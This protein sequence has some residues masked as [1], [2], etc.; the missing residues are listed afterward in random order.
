MK[1]NFNS[2]GYCLNNPLKYTDPS[3]YS[4]FQYMKDT[5]RGSE[6]FYYRGGEY[7]YGDDGWSYS[8]PSL[9]GGMAPA[10]NISYDGLHQEGY[11]YN[12]S[13]HNYHN[14]SGE[15]VTY[16]EVHNNYVIPNSDFS[17]SG[18]IAQDIYRA[19][20]QVLPSTN[21]TSS[22]DGSTGSSS[23]YIVSM[24]PVAFVMEANLSWEAA[25]ATSMTP[26]GMGLVLRGKNAGAVFFYS[27]GG[28]GGGW[29]GA[30]GAINTAYFFYSGD[31]NK[32]SQYSLGGKST[33]LSFSAGDGA[34]FGR[35]I[36]LMKDNYGGVIIGIGTS[37]GAGGSP[38]IVSGQITIQKTHIWP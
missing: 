10:A 34:T 30:A 38:T 23:E 4:Y 18:G 9:S 19:M 6:H 35:S 11:H 37:I 31:V 16:Y 1:Y 2:I 26:C 33:V 20:T 29:F 32:F 3:G 28:A 25:L 27:S 13:T 36:I 8:Q 21:Y 24:L 14:N 12:Y 5:Y 17:F 7:S 22:A 15:S